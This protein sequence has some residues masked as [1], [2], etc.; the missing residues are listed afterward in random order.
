MFPTSIL[1][2]SLSSSG[3]G[4]T[5]PQV[6]YSR[7]RVLGF[8]GRTGSNYYAL[9]YDVDSGDTQIYLGDIPSTAS[10][11]RRHG[12]KIYLNDDEYDISS[13]GNGG[14]ITLSSGVTQAYAKNATTM[15]FAVDENDLSLIPN[16]NA[17]IG[18]S[19]LSFTHDDYMSADSAIDST[20]N[21][22]QF[23]GL[24]F[25]SSDHATEYTVTSASRVA[26]GSDFKFTLGISP[27]W[28]HTTNTSVTITFN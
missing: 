20:Y 4:G 16:P 10:L 28:A 12:A 14:L 13:V 27:N 7:F 19:T 3:G 26:D 23:V 8:G 18:Q 11:I 2:G 17:S 24:T 6:N 25:T 1:H 5:P 9:N 21:I 22:G 15:H